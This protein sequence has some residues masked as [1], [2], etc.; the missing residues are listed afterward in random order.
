MAE[1]A[2]AA[3]LKAA[4]GAAP[5]RPV[6]QLAVHTV[7]EVTAGTEA[8]AEMAA[9][10]KAAAWTVVTLAV[11]MA[12]SWVGP[13][14][15]ERGAAEERAAVAMA[16]LVTEAVEE[17]ARGGAVEVWQAAESR[18]AVPQVAVQTAAPR[19]AEARAAEGLTAAPRVVEV[20][21]VVAAA[22]ARE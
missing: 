6:A 5:A 15:A 10:Q 2:A 3:V 18:A 21:A 19:V 1:G 14:A 20:A 13:T 22:R 9:V 7:V 11:L 12:A 8:A 16:D 17:M 4:A